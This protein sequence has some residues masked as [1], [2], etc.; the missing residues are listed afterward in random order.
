M[1]ESNQRKIA[2]P[3]DL[4]EDDPFAELTRIMGFDPRKPASP[5][6]KVLV[7][8]NNAKPSVVSPTVS[9]APAPETYARPDAPQAA[10]DDF[11][12]DLERELLGGFD[13]FDLPVEPVAK[14]SQA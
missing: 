3:I 1:A 8:A 10:D 4:D 2:D 6:P 12:I 11:G 7:G 5:E 14:P 9:N 13:D